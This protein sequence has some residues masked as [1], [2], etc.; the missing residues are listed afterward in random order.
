MSTG[1]VRQFPIYADDET[2]YGGADA[3][4]PIEDG[5]GI[6]GT[7]LSRPAQ[8]LR[9]RSETIRGIL[10]D[11][12]YLA[13][14]DRVLMLAGPG[15]VT[16]PGS[17]TSGSTGIFTI[18][19]VLY[20]L[21]ALSPGFAQTA[22]VPPVASNFG[23]LAINRDSDSMPSVGA[24]SLLRGYQGGDKLNITVVLDSVYSC[25]LA[26]ET[27]MSVVLTVTPTTQLSTIVTSLD[28]LQNAN[29]DNLMNAALINGALGT[30]VV[31]QLATQYYMELGYDAEGHALTPAQLAAFFAADPNNVLSE[32]DT[33]C[34]QYS[35]VIDESP[36][37]DGGR[38]QALPENSNTAITSGMLFNS[39]QNPSRI[40]NALPICKVINGRLVFIGGQQVPAGAA[41]FD[42]GTGHTS[43]AVADVLR[44]VV[45]SG[46]DEGTHAA[47]SF[48]VDAGVYWLN[49]VRL[50]KA[51][52]SVALA[53]GAT[54]YVYIDSTGNLVATAT[55]ATA[56]ALTGLILYRV[57]T[58]GGAI[59]TVTDLRRYLTKYNSRRFVTVGGENCDFPTLESAYAWT[60]LMSAAGEDTNFEIVIQGDVSMAGSMVIDH[61]VTISQNI[62]GV[63]HINTPSGAFAFTI[64]TG[65]VSKVIFKN[66][67]FNVPTAAGSGLLEVSGTAVCDDWEF[68][69]CT[70]IGGRDEHII[71]V[72]SG[73][74]KGWRIA[75]CK[76]SGMAHTA[77]SA[78]VL[79]QQ[80][81]GAVIEK[82]RIVGGLG[83]LF[84]AG[85]L[86]MYGSDNN[87][88]E[89]NHITTGGLGIAVVDIDITTVFDEP[90]QGNVI[91]KNTVI[92]TEES[93]IEVDAHNTVVENY[94]GDCMLSGGGSQGA[95]HVFGRD[96]IVAKNTIR[97]WVGGQAITL[98]ADS[99]GARVT[100]N[101]I[102][103][104]GSGSGLGVYSTGNLIGVTVANNYIDVE[105]GAGAGAG[106]AAGAAIYLLTC[107]NC[108]IVGNT[109]LNVG[110]TG[111]PS[112]GM[113][114]VGANSSIVG[115]NAV[116]C[117][118]FG[119]AAGTG[120]VIAGNVADH[121]D[122]DFDQLEVSGKLV[123]KGE[124]RSE[125]LATLTTATIT[126]D[127]STATL[128]VQ[129]PGGT[130][131]TIGGLTGGSKGRRIE[132]W[133]T[134]TTTIAIGHEEG[135]EAAG[136]RL[137][138]S[139]TADITIP[140]K[141]CAKAT[142]D[143][144]IS[145]WRAA[146]VG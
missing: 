77:L 70:I 92:G 44:N 103:K 19:D 74:H 116:N 126:L 7:V 97:N 56:V 87:V 10:E 24:T 53:D 71:D 26:D 83:D 121:A 127:E 98:N 12:L 30:D 6:N 94:L 80:M 3:V 13:D 42:L 68:D 84:D 123:F 33:L 38:R 85:I 37:T 43:I 62:A 100:E 86:V 57:V 65:T 104:S 128:Y 73:P 36:A 20:L 14:A 120:S 66:I 32:G 107:T 23:S 90:S 55:V 106:I 41:G 54:N 117:R 31:E 5:E 113:I 35:T 61:A 69:N 78:C 135:S 119:F 22:P 93:A 118:G 137:H 63:G 146:I 102:A 88:I 101:L 95:I 105:V 60:G 4:Q 130:T 17:L 29:G 96:V 111:S 21:P 27:T 131:H 46:F 34:V 134:G 2:G 47:L 144:S 140:A 110:T 115:N 9:L 48:E 45:I 99:H 125:S 59:T 124:Q 18:S 39:G 8:N 28:A 15:T 142:Y 141:G 133:N 129:C 139:G 138:C 40:P 143:D 64:A 75:N 25:V 67:R 136:D 122:C 49:G 72:R 108:V 114:L 145:R 50:N 51:V 52:D 82:N 109:I 112:L 91:S 11:L 16:W 1:T 58:A 132:I 89:N 81:T 79:L 76:F